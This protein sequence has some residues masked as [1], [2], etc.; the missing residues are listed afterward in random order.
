MP[1]SVAKQRLKS[2]NLRLSPCFAWKVNRAAHVCA[3]LNRILAKGISE[4][5]RL[6]PVRIACEA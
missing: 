1:P 6:H 5:R 2:L 3:A 4:L